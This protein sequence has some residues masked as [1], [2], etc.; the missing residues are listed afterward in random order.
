MFKEMT[1]RWGPFPNTDAALGAYDYFRQTIC[2]NSVDGAKLEAAHR[3]KM[4]G[5]KASGKRR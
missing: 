3:A 2:L 5:F 1:S 4:T